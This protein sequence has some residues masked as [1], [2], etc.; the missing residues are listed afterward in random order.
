MRIKLR[1]R[2]GL[3]NPCW[4]TFAAAA[5]N[6]PAATLYVTLWSTTSESLVEIVLGVRGVEVAVRQGLIK[7]NLG[8]LI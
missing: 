8:E 1:V 4:S 6:G 3:S 2:I 7:L 5:A